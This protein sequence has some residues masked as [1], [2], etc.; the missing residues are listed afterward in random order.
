MSIFM[1]IGARWC[2]T[3][4]AIFLTLP[5]LAVADTRSA[6]SIKTAFILNFV[7]FTDWPANLG[8]SDRFL[9][10]SLGAHVLSGNLDALQGRIVKGREIRVRESTRPSELHE[11]QVLFI[12]ADEESRVEWVLQRVAK[13]PVLTVSDAPN[14]IQSGGIIG[15]F[16]E[17]DRLRFDIN[18]AAARQNSLALSS[19]LLRLART[20]KQ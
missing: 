17:E 11:C 2:R 1:N 16:I 7:K 3:L 8:A 9:I 12:A 20:V 4:L 14:F 13:L 15:L 18:L 6:D 10:C 5:V 19:N